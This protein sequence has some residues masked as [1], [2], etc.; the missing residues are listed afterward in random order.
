MYYNCVVLFFIEYF[1]PN[2]CTVRQ[3]DL[4]QFK[5]SFELFFRKELKNCL[6]KTL[7]W[8]VPVEMCHQWIPN[9]KTF[10]FKGK[11]I[12]SSHHF[13]MTT[14]CMPKC[15]EQKN[16]K[17]LFLLSDYQNLKQSK[18]ILIT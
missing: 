3:N 17:L 9:H 4:K 18:I 15:A 12:S 2:K 6:I 13:K 7:A 8:L 1:C 16:V 5:N 14:V 10:T 11:R